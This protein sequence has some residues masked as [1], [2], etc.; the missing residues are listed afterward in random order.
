MSSNWLS[1]MTTDSLGL[2][3]AVESAQTYRAQYAQYAV[4]QGTTALSDSNYDGAIAAFKK[5]VALDSN[6]TTAYNYLGKIYL[7]QGNTDEAIKAYKQLVRIQSNTSTRDDS[8]SAPTW[9]ES[10]ISLGNAYLQA[11]KYD[12]SETQ[13]KLAERLSPSDPVPYYTLGMQYCDQDRLGEAM[14]QMQKAKTLSPSDG[15]VYYGLGKIQN[16]QGNYSDAVTSLQKALELKSSFPAAN[17]ELGV[18]YNALNYTDGV[19]EQLTILENS[20]T[21]LASQL[22]A[23]IKPQIESIDTSS[24]L[25]TFNSALGAG[26]PLWFLDS[27]LTTANSSKIFSVVIQFNKDMD[28]ESITNVANWSITRGNNAYS[29]YYNDLMAV[30][31]NEAQLSYVPLSVSYDTTTYEATVQFRL[32]QNSSG[33]AKID[34]KHIVFTFNGKDIYGQTMD[35]TANAIDGYSSDEAFGSVDTYV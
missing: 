33:T 28:A 1:S 22:S 17:Y 7:S 11:K 35:L 25:S 6:N 32:A 3:T 12:E 30:T 9:E 13:F 27:S 20:D 24:S 5:A 31:S 14:S 10:V 23:I 26:T 15:N 2:T 16:A 18:A 19:E 8:S 4:A 21:T 29:G 34:P